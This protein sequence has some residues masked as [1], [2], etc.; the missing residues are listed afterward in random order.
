[1]TETV[2]AKPSRGAVVAAC[3]F[4]LVGTL[5]ATSASAQAPYPGAAGYPGANRNPACSR[6][7]AQLAS[8]DRG[9]VD[10]ARAEEIRR[11][12]QIAN[13][14]QADLDRVNAQARR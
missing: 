13:R 6:L 11:L 9:N 1:M 5:A 14:Q 3:A 4:A 7:E 8:L 12:E 2:N 10:P